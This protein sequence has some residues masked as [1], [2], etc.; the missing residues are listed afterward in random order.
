MCREELGTLTACDVEN[1]P[2]SWRETITIRSATSTRDTLN[3]VNTSL[4]TSTVPVESKEVRKKK[5]EEGKVRLDSLTAVE[6]F[7]VL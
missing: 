4:T 7:S 6:K 1:D 3:N 2:T 5:E